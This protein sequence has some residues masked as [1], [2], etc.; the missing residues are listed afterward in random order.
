M[1]KIAIRYQKR[2][3]HASYEHDELSVE[4]M[5]DKENKTDEVKGLMAFVSDALNGK[6]EFATNQFPKKSYTKDPL[7]PAKENPKKETSAPAEGEKVADKKVE[8]GEK[9]TEKQGETKKLD[10]KPQDTKPAEEKKSETPA[11]QPKEKKAR[12]NKNTAYDSN[13]P[14]HKDNLGKWLDSEE[15][16]WR[17]AARLKFFI[18]ASKEMDGKDFYDAEGEILPAFKTEYLKLARGKE[19]EAAQ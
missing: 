1:E 12:G 16:G 7:S 6:N 4:I 14:Q 13:L 18:A 11:E 17:K 8:G 10:Q 5:A 15:T 2:V 19:Q 9:P 3:S